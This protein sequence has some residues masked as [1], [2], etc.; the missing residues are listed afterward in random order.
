MRLRTTLALILTAAAFAVQAETTDR[1]VYI[2]STRHTIHNVAKGETLYSLA[3][4][5]GVKIEELVAANPELADGL[6]AGQRLSIPLK[7]Q[8]GSRAEKRKA[9]NGFVRHTVAAKETLYSISRR[10]GVSVDDIVADNENIDPAHLSVGT[11]LYI[12]TQ[13]ERVKELKS[14]RAMKIESVVAETT[15]QPEPA[16]QPEVQQPTTPTIQVDMDSYKY[17]LVCEGE[18]V[19][20]IAQRFDTT[21]EYLFALNGLQSAE[22]IVKGRLIKVPSKNINAENTETSADVV[23]ANSA[24]SPIASI[25]NSE[26]RRIIYAPKD[27]LQTANVALLLPLGTPESPAQNY[28]DFYQGFLM[29]ADKVRAQGR[30]IDVSLFNTAHD[31]QRIN[32]ILGSGMLLRSDL[33]VGPVYEDELQYLSDVMRFSDT[34][35]VSPLAP[36][37]SVA[38]NNIYRMSPMPANKYDKV[39]NLLDGSHRVVFIKTDNNDDAFEQEVMAQLGSTPYDVHKYVYEHPSEVEKRAKEREATN[40][41][42]PS[43]MT[44]LLHG[45][46][47]TVFVITSNDETEVDRILA[48][49]A[50]ANISL[51]ARSRR[52]VPFR[53]IGNN[54][55]NRYASID[56]SILF[57]DRVVMLSTYHARRDN[58][59]LKE[60]D[61]RYVEEF[62]TL[63]SLYSYRGY[64]AAVIFLTALYKGL[65]TLEGQQVTPLQTPYTFTTDLA[66]GVRGNSEWVRV[67]Y[68]NNYTIT[69]E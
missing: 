47:P 13:D 5:Y 19:E 51:K 6:K 23:E 61:G 10:Y 68:N 15:A 25:L 60:F 37:E 40:T 53:I 63:P 46:K 50:S 52:I 65:E 29:G 38:G 2:N 14:G 1:I 66:T 16:P 44:P 55:W 64:D 11:E 36:L 4:H 30:S 24:P 39:R 41:Y 3:R 26:V 21:V 17:H 57:N 45:T 31:T 34:P 59:A 42:S 58:E 12:R 22:S 9:R 62:G 7:E 32:E 69:V 8:K 67:N 27:T 28:I 18:S 33:I 54:R 56:R 20:S 48:A 43:D 49:I 35:I